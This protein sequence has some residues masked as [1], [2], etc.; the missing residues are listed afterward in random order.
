M[1]DAHLDIETTSTLPDFS[2]GEFGVTADGLVAACRCAHRHLDQIERQIERRAER[3]TIIERAKSWPFGH[4]RSTWTRAD[5]SLFLAHVDELTFD[6][7]AE[8]DA[9]LRELACWERETD[10][11]LAAWGKGSILTHMTE[12][13]P[14]RMPHR[15]RV[16][17][18]AHR[19][20]A[21][22]ADQ[23]VDAGARSREMTM[24]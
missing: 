14:R 15:G 12:L 16:R 7:R 5:E 18:R 22:R 1:T 21:T 23:G 11:H 20:G 10:A 4:R 17:D 3:M 19:R 8:I 24:R 6:R 9:L 13:L 2:G